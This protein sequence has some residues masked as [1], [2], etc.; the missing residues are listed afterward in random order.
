MKKAYRVKKNEDFGAIIRARHSAANHAFVVYV[1]PNEIGHARVG[2]SVSKKR[3]K[4][5][6]RN[7]IKRQVRMM[8][9]HVFNLQESYDYVVIVRDGFLEGT[10]ADNEAKL[11]KAY[12]KS[13]KRM[14][15]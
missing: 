13:K 9:Q 12:E 11:R 14:G 15:T 7:L 3:G 1:R 5:H 2:V 10:F 6:T 8:V 4:A